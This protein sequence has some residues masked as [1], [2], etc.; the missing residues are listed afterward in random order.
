[1]AKWALMGADRKYTA[2]DNHSARAQLRVQGAPRLLPDCDQGLGL[3]S[4]MLVRLG[5]H[6]VLAVMSARGAPSET[7]VECLT[8]TSRANCRWFRWVRCHIDE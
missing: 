7:K 5:N 1:M 8:G 2:V 4:L 3:L 6:C